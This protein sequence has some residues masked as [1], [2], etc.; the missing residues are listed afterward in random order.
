MSPLEVSLAAVVGYLIGSVPFAVLIGR[1]RGVDVLREGSRNP[2][3]TN[4]GRV[5]GRG[6]GNLCFALDA[7]K[8]V[9]SAGWPLIA[10]GSE[11]ARLVFGIMGL[12]AAIVG[13]SF[14]VFS[15]FQGG[16]GVATT[17]GGLLALMPST[18]LIG[19]CVWL[20]V[21]FATRYVSL[22]SI[23]FGL[24]LPL[25]GWLLGHQEAAMLLAIFIAVLILVRHRSNIGRLL[26]G[27]E[28]RIP[29]RGK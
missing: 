22:A 14:S 8:G 1:A 16:K 10:F 13:H 3:A 17:M 5:V 23:C 28:H 19:L 2:G 12:V 6:A 15:R 11:E 21:Y 18:L 20:A 9:I 24:S 27:T 26:A 4:V 7:G 29:S 25:S